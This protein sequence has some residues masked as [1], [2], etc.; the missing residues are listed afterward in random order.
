MAFP[1]EAYSD[2]SLTD[3]DIR[4]V[5]VFTAMLHGTNAAQEKTASTYGDLGRTA[6]QGLIT[7]GALFGTGLAATGAVAG[8]K[9]LHH[10][11]TRGRELKNILEVYPD[12]KSDYADRDVNLAFNSIRH[13]N[14]HYAKDPLVGGTLLKQVL[15]NRYADNP[16]AMRFE[17]QL[18]SVLAKD[19][20]RKDTSLEELA[21]RSFM[22]GMEG[23]IRETADQRRALDD[24]TWRGQQSADERQWRAE[25]EDAKI[26]QDRADKARD[27]GRRMSESAKMRQHQSDLA[28]TR[29]EREKAMKARETGRR[30]SDTSRQREHQEGLERLK[31]DLRSAS[32]PRPPSRTERLKKASV[33]SLRDFL[34]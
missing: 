29:Y 17:P 34:R 23:A 32:Q 5:E 11:L 10:K 6:L 18:A 19:A 22:G 28:N 24:R 26:R 27:A 15:E 21:A 3:A 16:D 33:P 7:G 9:A 30:L 8:A 14:P 2:M 25:R 12:I 31:A 13:L 4:E 1:T 20:P